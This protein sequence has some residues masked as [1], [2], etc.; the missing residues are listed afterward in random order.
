MNKIPEVQNYAQ[1]R[2]LFAQRAILRGSVAAP[3]PASL[4]FR[5]SRA[6][7]GRAARGTI[8]STFHRRRSGPNCSTPAR[9]RRIRF[10]PVADGEQLPLRQGGS[11][12]C[13]FY[14]RF[15]F[16]FSLTYSL[17]FNKYCF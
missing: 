9:C 3:T 6:G 16:Y 1:W 5:Q 11:D 14:L 8:L 2:K 10:T 17:F 7:L 15:A 13:A 12:F 4:D